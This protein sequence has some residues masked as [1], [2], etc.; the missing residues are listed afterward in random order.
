MAMFL[1]QQSRKHIDTVLLMQHSHK[2]ASYDYAT[3][4]EMKSESEKLNQSCVM[5]EIGQ[6]G[7]TKQQKAKSKFSLSTEHIACNFDRDSF[8]RVLV[9]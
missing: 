4:A 6:S 3:N 1:M 7:S 8:D 9:Q 5:L 2:K